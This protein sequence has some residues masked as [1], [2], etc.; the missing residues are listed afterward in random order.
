M[1]YE[2]FQEDCLVWPAA[3]RPNSI[4]SVVTDPPFGLLEYTSREL[5]KL[6]KRKGGVWRIPPSMGGCERKPVPRFTVLSREELARLRG[7]F[8]RWGELILRVL[9]PGGHVFVASN[10]LLSPHLAYA[11]I[12]S[13]FERR[14]EIVRLVRTLRGGDRPKLAEKEFDCISVIPRGCYEPWGLYRKPLTEQRVS[15]NL[16]RWSAGALRRTPDK[17]PFRDVLKSET[18]PEC[19]EK[20]ALHPSLKPQRFLRQ[21]VWASLPL[22]KG[23]ILDPFMGSGSTLAAAEALNYKS[24]GIEADSEFVSIAKQ[25]IPRLAALDVDWTSFEG[26]NGKVNDSGRHELLRGRSTRKATT[27]L[28]SRL[29]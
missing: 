2:I 4:H 3:R 5:S 25:A 7:Y 8:T 20:I 9:V 29:W 13:G 24:I 23:I 18:P 21:L 11:L 28:Q 17:R 19:E 26:P 10:P 22:G 1:G 12:T 14:G 15:L 6:R 27:S 16:K